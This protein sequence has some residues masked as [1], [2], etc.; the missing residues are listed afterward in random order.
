[1]LTGVTENLPTG[2]RR[3]ID[4]RRGGLPFTGAE[5]LQHWDILRYVQMGRPNS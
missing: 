4:T 1:M 5:S 3:H 2:E